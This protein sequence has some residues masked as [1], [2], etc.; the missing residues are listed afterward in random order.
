MCVDSS[1]PK[2]STSLQGGIGAIFNMSV[3]Q[4]TLVVRVITIFRVLG[5]HRHHALHSVTLGDHMCFP[6]PGA[7]IQSAGFVSEIITEITVS[8]WSGV[9]NADPITIPSSAYPHWLEQGWVYTVR[10]LQSWQAAL[11]VG[12]SSGEP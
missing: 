7:S 4:P 10:S 6:Y 12:L 5:S 1:G 11:H 8:D 3:P 2:R 9:F